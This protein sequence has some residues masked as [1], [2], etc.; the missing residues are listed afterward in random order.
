MSHD[1]LAREALSTVH[2]RY[3]GSLPPVAE[4]PLPPVAEGSLPPAGPRGTLYPGRA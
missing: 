4:G 3:E 2:S 1:E